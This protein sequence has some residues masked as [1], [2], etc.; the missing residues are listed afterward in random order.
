MSRDSA[1]RRPL[2]AGAV[3]K[4]VIPMVISKINVYLPDELAEWV[5]TVDI[6]VTAITR[7]A[8]RRERLLREQ[9][10]LVAAD[11]AAGELDEEEVTRWRAR[12]ARSSSTPRS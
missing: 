9:A 11:R 2:H 3:A 8:L 6:N 5:K 7:E 12:L 10:Q 4:A 1:A